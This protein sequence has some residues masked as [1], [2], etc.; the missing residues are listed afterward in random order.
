MS[1]SR[2]EE[3]TILPEIARK[4]TELFTPVALGGPKSRKKTEAHKIYNFSLVFK[5]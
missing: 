5:N 3:Q 2:P 1:S 4:R